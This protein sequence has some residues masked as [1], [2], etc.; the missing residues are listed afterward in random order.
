[1]Q[2]KWIIGAV[3]CSPLLAIP[4]LLELAGLAVLLSGSPDSRSTGRSCVEEG[5]P[6]TAEA[7][8]TAA[9]RA[10]PGNVGAWSLELASRRLE[11]DTVLRQAG[12][13]AWAVEAIAGGGAALRDAAVGGKSTVRVDVEALDRAL[14]SQATEHFAEAVLEKL[15]VCGRRD[16]KAWS[17]FVYSENKVASV[18]PPCSPSGELSKE[19]VVFGLAGLNPFQSGDL[20]RLQKLEVK[21]PLPLA[22]L[23]LACLAVFVCLLVMSAGLLHLPTGLLGGLSAVVAGIAG[24]VSL[25]CLTSLLSSASATGGEKLLQLLPTGL[26]VDAQLWLSVVLAPLVQL[27]GACALATLAGTIKA[28]AAALAVLGLVILALWFHN[29]RRGSEE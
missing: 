16:R 20:A 6:R 15:P 18:P 7:T 12:F 3:L 2:K 8:L 28:G 25:L 9:S 24:P 13:Y 11:L 21:T 1:M 27:A 26:S 4:L 22:A 29:T 23:M 14:S 5:L 10:A 19:K 17:E